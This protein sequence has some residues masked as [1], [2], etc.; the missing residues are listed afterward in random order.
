MNPL[1][2]R[3]FLIPF[4]RIEPEH[5]E[6]GVREALATAQ[7]ELDAIVTQAAPYTYDSTLGALD[8][9]SERLDR[10]VGLGY[11]LMSVMNSPELRRAFNAVLPKFSAFYAKLPLN[12]GL[13]RVIKG[14]S[15]TEEARKLTGVRRRH[16]EKTLRAFQRAGAD[17]PEGKKARAEA[18][19]IELSKLQ[20]KFSEHVLDATNAFELVLTEEA[21]L[22]GLPESA[23]AQARESA[24]AKDKEGY[25]FTLQAPSYLPFMQYAE[26][27]HLRQKMYEAYTSRATGGEFDN[28]P[29]VSRILEL[30]RELTEL[31]E[32]Q[33]FADLRLEESMVKTGAAAHVFVQNLGKRTRPHWER[34]VEELSRFARDELGLERLEPWD[35]VYVTERLRKA[36]YDLDEEALRP[37]F[38]VDRVLTGLFDIVGRLFG[39]TVTERA[40]SEVWHPEVAFYDLHDE[41]GTHLG[42]FYADWFPRES[43]RGG[44][45]MNAFI[46]GGP[47]E[48]GF[49]PHL[50]LMVGNF[51]P[52]QEGK[53]ALLTHREVE[54]TFHE[55][56]H[57]LHHLLS[58]VS[59]PALA[60]TNVPLDWVELPSQ[61]ME[62]WCWEREALDLFARHFETGETIPE[63]LFQ[64]MLAA[65]TFMAANAQMRQLSFGDVDLALH[66]D[67]HPERDGDVVRYAQERMESYSIRP[68]FAHNGFIN[69]FSHVFAG[70]YAA[71][72]YSYKWSEVLDADAFTRFS[73]EGIFNRETGRDYVDTIL[74]RG[75]ADDPDKLYR[76]FMGRDPDMNALMRRNLGLEEPVGADD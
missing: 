7:G 59:E 54:T 9:L 48:D 35:V 3:D 41:H 62:N 32:Y 4:D 23:L 2:S 52:P 43:K 38:P 61:I 71:G 63:E 65:R 53:P 37:Y 67:Y 55:F 31:L 6:P 34:E 42:S 47:Q 16:L 72:Y 36:K 25:R 44:A 15:E 73:K 11:H 8:R 1:L 76:D 46:T 69:A 51:T 57:L 50:G 24:R 10:V 75:D 39:V 30:R 60:G 74:S 27:R 66:I 13:W 49:A 64:K 33:D 45:W 26:A 19:N 56:G 17:L 20:T 21:D 58:T 18:I 70:G 68:E 40:I 12:D 14:F 5:V 29:L 22:I 28:Q